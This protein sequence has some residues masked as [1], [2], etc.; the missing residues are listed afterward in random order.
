MQEIGNYTCCTKLVGKIDCIE[1]TYSG[2][3]G[4]MPTKLAG[5]KPPI[6]QKSHAVIFFLKSSSSR[7]VLKGILS[8]G[9][10]KR[11]SVIRMKPRTAR[12]RDPRPQAVASSANPTSPGTAVPFPQIVG[13]ISR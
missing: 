1:Y 7:V 5:K 10:S 3:R 11:S 4:A 13:T 6:G 9:I 2:I 12:G 8:G